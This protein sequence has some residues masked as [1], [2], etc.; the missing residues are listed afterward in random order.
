[1]RGQSS[2]LPSTKSLKS[3]L[4]NLLRELSDDESDDSNHADAHPTVLEDPNQP[5]LRDFRAYLDVVEYVPDGWTTI[6]WWGVSD[7][8]CLEMTLTWF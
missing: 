1:M 4:N 6:A 2:L 7:S 3:K 5:W 8:R